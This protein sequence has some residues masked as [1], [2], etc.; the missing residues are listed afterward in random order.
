MLTRLGALVA[1]HRR[2][3]L[4]VWLLVAIGGLIAAPQVF[5]RLTSNVGNN[6]MESRL[7]SKA[8][9][10]A[11]ASAATI[12]VLVD[13]I[14][15]RSTD[16]QQAI[17]STA[18]RLKAID[19]VA[20]VVSPFPGQNKYQFATDGK[21]VIISVQL[22]KDV[23]NTGANEIVKQVRDQ[24]VPLKKQLPHA[25]VAVGGSPA[26]IKDI[27]TQVEKDLRKAEF[28][29]L[30]ITAIVLI[31]VFGGFIAAGI[32][33]VAAF[34]Q[35]LSAM[36]ILL[37]FS[38][39]TDLDTNVVPVCT[40]MGLALA[41]DYS[42]LLVNRYREFRGLGMNA[43]EAVA[44]GV[45]TAGRTVFFSA[46]TVAVS[47]A[48]LFFFQ[49]T[50]YR[51][52]A[53][54]GVSI[55]TVALLSSL[56]LTPALLRSWEKRIKAP[57]SPVSHDGFF[58]RLARFV[59]RRPWP[60]IVIVTGLLIAMAIPIFQM[61]LSLGG[62][63]MLPKTTES[64]VV[65]L[66]I[67]ARFP[68]LQVTPIIGVVQGT[69]S[70]AEQ[71]TADANNVAGV[72][73]AGPPQPANGVTWV[74]P[75]AVKGA[76]ESRASVQAVHDLRALPEPPGSKV[77]VGGT[78]AL[79]VDIQ[80]EI[81]QRGPWAL[82]WIAL[83]TLLL[84]FLLTGSVLVPVKALIMNVLS[85]CATFGIVVLIFQ[86]GFGH[87]L[88]N[89]QELG[90]L[91]SFIPVLVLCFAFGLSMDYEVFLISRIKELHD[92]GMPNDQAVE[93]GLQRTGRIITSAALIMVIVF[94]G[95]SLG[96]IA[97]VKQMGVA[98]AI[99]VTIDATLV[100]ML[101]V[102]ATMTVLGELNWWAPKWLSRAYN[103]FGLRESAEVE[104]LTS[105]V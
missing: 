78:T 69:Q 61:E 44:N 99:A 7:A 22:A 104:E 60:V 87:Q 15:P 39:V 96:Y 2:I 95:F 80:N 21:G 56:T 105:R 48:G 35:I 81:W 47:L 75:I 88:F 29:T 1:R 31:L 98:L 16:V 3:V 59:H 38:Y 51:T 27:N 18:A 64:R 6:A 28:I 46:M 10:S 43:D 26:V 86:K 82:L 91:T 57:T 63:A 33:L 58:A 65:D 11:G 73:K 4:A 68:G 90:G 36:L 67:S 34:A 24:V 53:A 30:P 85:L 102:P 66:A 101:L 76:P 83:A 20:E 9:Q 97:G 23:S 25:T 89:V 32:P 42:L 94:M 19:G 41:I 93:Q 5:S 49:S 103:R 17:I 92:T 77:L 13:N 79:L 37:G 14:D 52:I 100:R 12:S 74:V 70:A 40:V 62:A 71:W 84:L 45:G 50:L 72:A 54:A 8:L 55:V